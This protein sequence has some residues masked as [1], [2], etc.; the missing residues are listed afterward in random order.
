[1][2]GTFMIWVVIEAMV[3][4]FAHILDGIYFGATA[5]RTVR[6]AMLVTVFAVYFPAFAV[7][8]RLAGNHGMWAATVILMLTRAA[9]LAV[10]LALAMRRPQWR[11]R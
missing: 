1:M 11:L 9:S 3:G 8:E 2:A 6:N 7:L 5:T 10:P 4:S